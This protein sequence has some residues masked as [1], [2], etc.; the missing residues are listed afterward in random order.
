MRTHIPIVI[1]TDGGWDDWLALLFL[2]K[3]PEIR[4]LGVTVTG[5]GEAHLGP[6]V[7]NMRQLLRFGQQT[8]QVYAGTRRP[9]IY[10]NEFP[11]SFRETIDS[12]FGI[13]I[14]PPPGSTLAPPSPA[15][16]EDRI[17]DATTFLHETLVQAAKTNMPVTLLCIG[18]FTNLG[19]L[20]QQYPVASYR[21]GIHRIYAMGGAIAV[22][23]NV[24]TFP[25]ESDLEW[26]YY[27][28]YTAEW[29]IFV[30]VRGAELA[31]TAGLPI[32]LIPLDAAL[33][34]P[35]TTAFVNRFARAAGSDPYAGFVLN[36]LQKQTGGT[37]FFDAL[38]AAAM[39]AP[40]DG[41][42]VTTTPMRLRVEQELD[43]EH[44]NVGQLVP[45][46]AKPWSE[47]SVATTANAEIFYALFIDTI[48]PPVHSGGHTRRI[49][50]SAPRGARAAR[51]HRR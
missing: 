5:V 18:G 47:I 1:D 19:T 33:R 28:N 6:A 21:A 40:E 29:N 3:R 39:V 20:L 16:D 32:T 46:D 41:G 8:A 25:P 9:L 34:V 49:S 48:R 4:I 51:A 37:W 10:S 24:Y 50:R 11:A 27:E 43:E 7:D 38:A 22:P 12:M 26:S 35:V 14:P 31:M 42:L 45:T 13:T 23:G 15:R 30:D 36:V 17:L 44:N 2:M